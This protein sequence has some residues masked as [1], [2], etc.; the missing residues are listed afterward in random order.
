MNKIYFVRHSDTYSYY[1]LYSYGN[2]AVNSLYPSI[3]C[4]PQAATKTLNVHASS[5]ILFGKTNTL[6]F[7]WIIS[8]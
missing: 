1:K 3:S 4:A 7:Y 6:N 8:P 5:H 2:T